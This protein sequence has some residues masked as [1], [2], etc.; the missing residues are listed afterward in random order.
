[1]CVFILQCYSLFENGDFAVAALF[2]VHGGT[3]GNGQDILRE[4]GGHI[5]LGFALGKDS[6][7]KVYPVALFL[8][9]GRVGG[10]L[11]GGDETAEGSAAAGGEENDLATCRCQ[12][13]GGHKVIPGGR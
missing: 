1:M 9:K 6:R 10:Y 12:C 5:G 2:V 7:V 4:A 3:G 8:V 13:R 11:H